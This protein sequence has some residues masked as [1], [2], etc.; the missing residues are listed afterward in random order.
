MVSNHQ[1]GHTT[2]HENT[3]K[4]VRKLT[5]RV[6]KMNTKEEIQPYMFES[7]KKP[8]DESDSSWETEEEFSDIDE[9]QERLQ[10]RN[11]VNIVNKNI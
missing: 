3:Q 2:R 1:V 8:G 11:E 10:K 6:V 7:R 9:F 4:I 5:E